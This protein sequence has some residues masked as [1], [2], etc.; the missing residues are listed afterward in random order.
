MARLILTSGVGIRDGSKRR[1]SLFRKIISGG[2]TG[3][4]F[5]MMN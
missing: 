4:F 5:L 2:K 3:A 1:V